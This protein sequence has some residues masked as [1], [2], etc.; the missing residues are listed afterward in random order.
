MIILDVGTCH[1]SIGTFEMF[2]SCFGPFW[3]QSV[4]L[5]AKSV[6][7]QGDSQLIIGQVNEACD[8][9]E[10]QM[11]RYLKK[12]KH[13]TKSFT[14]AK[15]HQIPKEENMEANSLAKAASADIIMNEQVR[16]QYIPSIDILE[17]Q[18]IDEKPIGLHQ[19]YLKDGIVLEEK[20]KAQS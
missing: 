16:I 7:I 12:V 17:V 1:E 2:F 9:K 3:V 15:F 10:E 11:K 13:C 4:T 8:V 18:Q 19:L 14:S 20:E 6:V 5:G